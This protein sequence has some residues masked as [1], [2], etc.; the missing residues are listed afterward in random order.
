MLSYLVSRVSVKLRSKRLSIDFGSA[1]HVVA[2]LRLVF[3]PVISRCDYPE[4]LAYVEPLVPVSQARCEDG[5]VKA[6]PDENSGLVEVK[7]LHRPD[8]TRFGMVIRLTDIWRPVDVVPVFEDECES[9]WTS[10][11]AID[12]AQSFL[13]NVFYTKDA[14][15]CLSR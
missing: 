5:V 3:Q 2:Q 9:D 6:A 15:Q 12:K 4:I 14:F 1:G 11:T 7:R 10:D 13:I 8:R